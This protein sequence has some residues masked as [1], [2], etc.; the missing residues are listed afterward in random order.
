M[1]NDPLQFADDPG[2]HRSAW[3]ALA[4]VGIIAIWFASGMLV[5]DED[6]QATRDA[7]VGEPVSVAVTTS[8]AEPV[9]ETF[10]AEGQAL[11]DRDTRV[12]AETSGAIRE[13]LIR[14]G[15]KV[16][17]EDL[18]ARIDPRQRTAD[19]RRAEA[20]LARTRRELEN[21]ET[22]L[23]RGATTLDRV[24]SARVEFAAAEAALAAARQA[25]A[26]TE[27]RAPFAG[28]LEE[29]AIDT[30]EFVTAGTDLARVVD[31]DPLTIEARV[32]QKSLGRLEL[33]QS[34]NIH[35]ITGERRTG[36]VSFLG[37]TADP[38][39]RTFALE[40]EV[41]NPDGLLTAGISVEV[42]IPTGETAAHFV[43]P[44]ILALDESGAL[45]LKTVDEQNRVAFQPVEILKAQT[46]GVWVT[47]L[48]GTTRII[49]VGQ[50]FVRAGDTVDPRPDTGAREP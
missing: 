1:P 49:S 21:A 34:A 19:L 38:T 14:K 9:S 17:A 23:D 43:S 46:N 33:G 26:D 3:S 45:G 36:T 15:Q 30:G 4:L 28:Q 50:G 7:R 41:A 13:V 31:S 2:A 40:V 24:V 48:P 42:R 47:G 44:A 12:R 8:T 18:I 25:I 5:P 32:P 10:V 29:L 6:G 20:D 27:I 22:L 39:T 16:A 35:F 11:P 37:S